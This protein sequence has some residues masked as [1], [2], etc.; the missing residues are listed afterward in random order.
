MAYS[1]TASDAEDGVVAASGYRWTFTIH[2]CVGGACHEHEV[3][4]VVGVTSGSFEMP[5][6]EDSFLR[7]TLEVTDSDGFTAEATRDLQ[8]AA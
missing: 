3:G 5:A 4:E 2:H 1:G 6:H 7:I 8:M